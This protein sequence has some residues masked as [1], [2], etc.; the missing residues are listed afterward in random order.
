MGAPDLGEQFPSNDPRCL[1]INSRLF[2]KSAYE[3][4][5]RSGWTIENIDTTIIA[6]APS[7]VGYKKRIAQSIGRL[8][9]ID[10]KRVSVK[11]KTT[12]AFC[13]GKGGIADFAV[14]LL[15][16]AARK[17]IGKPS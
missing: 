10:A 1:N 7:L 17:R 8:I 16:H 12:E 3:Q 2:V 13:P 6:D 15:R 14:V 4:V 5:R 9:N 11:A